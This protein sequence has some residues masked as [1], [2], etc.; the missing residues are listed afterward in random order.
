[1]YDTDTVDDSK[2]LAKHVNMPVQGMF[3]AY[4]IHKTN[5]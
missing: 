3:Q 1:M 2:L 5:P 4:N